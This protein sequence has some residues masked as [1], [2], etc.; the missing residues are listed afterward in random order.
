MS[1]RNSASVLA[2]FTTKVTGFTAASSPSIFK[3]SRPSFIASRIHLDDRAIHYESKLPEI[4][5]TPGESS[6]YH[7]RN[8]KGEEWTQTKRQCSTNRVGRHEDSDVNQQ[9]LQK[10]GVK[11]TTT[12]D[13]V[14]VHDVEYLVRTY[15]ERLADAF[16]PDFI[17]RYRFV[18][19]HF[20]MPENSDGD[21]GEGTVGEVF[22]REHVLFFR[23]RED[24]WRMGLNCRSFYVANSRR[25]ESL[26][27]NEREGE[28]VDVCD[29]FH[30]VTWDLLPVLATRC[31][32]HQI[33]QMISHAVVLSD[34][35]VKTTLSP[36]FIRSQ[37]MSS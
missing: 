3:F 25:I 31:F 7:W 34:H 4:I 8:A 32:F 5:P 9:L 10:H 29:L 13:I 18:D 36:Q 21:L 11:D 15:L 6:E 1:R 33:L 26:P 19:H 24:W 12:E 23:E 28:R 16:L 22:C 17:S 14:T 37:G 35:P 30:R 27:C 2:R 20:F